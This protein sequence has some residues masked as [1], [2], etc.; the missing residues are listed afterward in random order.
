MKGLSFEGSLL[1][2]VGHPRLSKD[3]Y[4]GEEHRSQ[5]D[6]VFCPFQ[7]CVSDG[8]GHCCCH[9][10]EVF[11][12]EALG[13][14]RKACLCGLVA[15]DLLRDFLPCLTQFPPTW[16]VWG[17][18]LSLA[19]ILLPTL[20]VLL[21]TYHP[22]SRVL[23]LWSRDP[24]IHAELAIHPTLVEAGVEGWA[25]IATHQGTHL[26]SGSILQSWSLSVT[27]ELL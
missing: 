17:G 3:G 5:H 25:S 27:T 11:I 19:S 14:F 13:S 18:Q 12:Q 10:A 15:S 21:R 26:E 2:L 23:E 6:L 7:S 22:L 16:L 9:Q 1:V 4:R 20:G 24:A 8:E